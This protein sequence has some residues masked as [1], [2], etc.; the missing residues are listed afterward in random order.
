MNTFA[1]VGNLED[2]PEVSCVYHS[3]QARVHAAFVLPPCPAP[4]SRPMRRPRTN[5]CATRL[6]PFWA[7]ENRTATRT[8]IA[9]L[10]SA[11]GAWTRRACKFYCTAL[12]LQGVWPQP[13]LHPALGPVV[14]LRPKRDA[15]V[16]LQPTDARRKDNA[17]RV[18]VRRRA[19]AVPQRKGTHRSSSRAHRLSHVGD[20]ACSPWSRKR[21]HRAGVNKHLAEDPNLAQGVV[22]QLRWRGAKRAK[23]LETRVSYIERSEM[24]HLKHHSRRGGAQQVASKRVARQRASAVFALQAAVDRPPRTRGARPFGANAAERVEA[25]QEE[26]IAARRGSDACQC[27]QQAA[28]AMP[29]QIAIPDVYRRAPCACR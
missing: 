4:H 19:R 13:K 23:S 14:L 15:I 1:F 8:R 6:Q 22:R 12:R 21:Q 18:T 2:S 29:C 24:S 7:T 20:A 3:E 10:I 9:T 26:A 28:S 16:D 27:R 17:L 25:A 5:T 11:C